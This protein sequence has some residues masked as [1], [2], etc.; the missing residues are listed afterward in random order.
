VSFAQDVQVTLPPGQSG[1]I[2]LE[3]GE[4]GVSYGPDEDRRNARYGEPIILNGARFVVPAR[5]A[6]KSL[7]LYV[8]PRYMAIDYLQAGLTTVMQEG[9]GGV[10]VSFTSTDASI[11]PRVVNAAVEEYQKVNEE[12]A[13]Q[14]VRRRRAFLEE[15]LR[16]TDSLLMAAQAGLSGFRARE[17]AYSVAG[18]FTAEQ[19]NLI[20]VEI[21]QAQM[22]ADLRLQENALNKVLQGRATGQSDDMSSLMASG[23]GS[24]PV[25][26]GLY[27]QLVAFR[28]ERDA[29]LAGPWARAPTHPDVQRLDTL[30]AATQEKLMEAARDHLASLRAQVASLGSLRGRALGQM[31]NLPRTEVEEVYLTQNLAA[32]QQTG[33]QLR[34]QYQAVRLEEAAEGGVVEIVQLSTLSFPVTT[35]PWNKLLLGL[36]AGLNRPEDIEQ[37]LLIPNLA[38]IPAATPYLLESGNGVGSRSSLDPAGA[39]AYRI[40]RANLL[41]SQG[42]LKTL[43]VTSAAPGEGKTLTA[44]NLS[45]A[46]AR[47]GLRVLLMECD[48]RRP[49]LKHFFDSHNG[50]IDLN[51]V[52]LENRAW[53]DAIHPSG[54][55]GLDLLLASRAVPRAAEFLAGADMKDLLDQL[56]AQ[57]DMVILD[58]SPLLV[59]ADATVL[60][61]IADGVLL[62]VRAT[63]TDRE[64][65]QQAM[66]HLNLVNARVVGTVLNDPDGSV[67]RYGAYY[68]YSAAYEGE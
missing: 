22:L 61:A 23:I 62:V 29:M 9:T 59:A 12:L 17:Q 5:P 10:D 37:L 53:R 45:A 6:M 2:N 51:D 4:N 39:E 41:F 19:G 47:Q 36:M 18:R 3:F 33:D 28:N 32:L 11:P 26:S 16:T 55:P 14:N 60:G 57:Y 15:Q 54:V 38:V 56:S 67:A 50:G 42:G 44:V 68:D 58:T 13:R 43:V 27:S 65:V 25:V 1:T 35:S 64:A 46:I 8:F 30:I 7:K 66:H 24:S 63:H 31:S 52:L 48:L 40:L 49:S 20:Q 34:D 21:Q